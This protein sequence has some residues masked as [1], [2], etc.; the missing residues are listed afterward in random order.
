[1]CMDV[2]CICGALCHVDAEFCYYIKCS[3]CGRVFC[4]GHVELIEL[5]FEPDTCVQVAY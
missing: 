5:A 3:E 2:H 4:N 1:V